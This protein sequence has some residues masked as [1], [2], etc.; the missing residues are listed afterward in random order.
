MSSLAGRRERGK[1]VELFLQVKNLFLQIYRFT[2][3]Q[4]GEFHPAFRHLKLTA[5]SSLAQVPCHHFSTTVSALAGIF[6]SS[7]EETSASSAGE[8]VAMK[9]LSEAGSSGSSSLSRMRI[10]NLGVRYLRE[11]LAPILRVKKFARLGIA[12]RQQAKHRNIMRRTGRGTSFSRARVSHD[13]LVRERRFGQKRF[14]IGTAQPRAG[15]S[16]CLTTSPRM[17]GSCT[18][19]TVSASFRASCI[20]APS[21]VKIGRSRS[22]RSIQ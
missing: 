11:N 7:H 6:C 19:A 20:F 9:A 15:R 1:L 17:S 13:H 12:Q 16:P 22:H 21:E 5:Q 10:E 3:G 2:S 14:E 18:R 8:R 4:A